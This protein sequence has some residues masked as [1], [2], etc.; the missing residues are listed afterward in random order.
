MINVLNQK[1]ALL[2]WPVI[3]R[4]I[5]TRSQQNKPWLLI[6]K[7]SK[8]IYLVR[9]PAQSQVKSEIAMARLFVQT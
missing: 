3:D 1:H 4:L 6:R 9:M 8:N 5:S 7:S 2:Q